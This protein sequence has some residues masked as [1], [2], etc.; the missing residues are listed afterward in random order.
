MTQLFRVCKER[1]GRF[2]YRCNGRIPWTCGRGYGPYLNSYIERVINDDHFL[3]A[4][5]ESGEVPANFGM[6]L[7]ERVIELPWVL[8]KL[9]QYQEKSR[10]LDAG[11]ALNHQ[12]I[13]QHPA[14][15]VH[16][17]TVLTLAPES[18]CFWEKGISYVFDDL[19]SMPF[20]DGLFDAVFCVS[21]IEHIGMDN[22]SYTADDRYR[23]NK[24][25]DHLRAIAEMRRTLR[26]NGW[27]YLTVPFGRYE[28]HG[29]LQQFDTTMLSALIAHF[30]PQH[31]RK[32]FFRYGDCGWSVATEGQ[33]GDS[34]YSHIGKFCEHRESKPPRGSFAPTASAV[35]CVELQ[36]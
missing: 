4:L 7:C 35:A 13:L 36:K 19:R 2:V 31:V 1:L 15:R 21:V 14:A 16:S 9:S 11:S 26:P 33:C 29:W 34:S 25:L 18:N 8:A 27:L 3:R 32:T 24:P 12:M 23:E 10:F 28:N 17:W 22:V 30:E 5:Q 6:R 20:R